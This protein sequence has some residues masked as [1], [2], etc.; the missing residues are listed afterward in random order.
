MVACAGS[1]IAPMAGWMYA[2]RSGLR[3]PERQLHCGRTWQLPVALR[4]GLV[5]LHTSDRRLGC[6]CGMDGAAQPTA[7][8]PSPTYGPQRLPCQRS[9]PLPPGFR[10]P[11]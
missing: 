11:A 10:A 3:S 8:P 5:R 1:C 2:R 4:T 6:A 7:H 9:S